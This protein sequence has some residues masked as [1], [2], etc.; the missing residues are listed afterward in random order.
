MLYY[1][2]FR[3][4]IRKTSSA[5][6]T[7]VSTSNSTANTKKSHS[8]VPNIN[9][10]NNYNFLANSMALQSLAMQYPT[11]SELNYSTAPS[12][13]IPY[14]PDL[15]MIAAAAVGLTPQ[16]SSLSLSQMDILSHI[17]MVNTKYPGN[18][19][20]AKSTSPPKK[21]NVPSPS[22]SS[23]RSTTPVSASASSTSSISEKKKSNDTAASK[24]NDMS[25]VFP[26][27]T[28]DVFKID[29]L[30]NSTKTKKEHHMLNHI[31]QYNKHYS[32]K[33]EKKNTYEKKDENVPSVSPV[34]HSSSSNHSVSNI[35]SKPAVPGGCAGASA[36]I[37]LGQNKIGI[38]DQVLDLSPNKIVKNEVECDNT[39]R[40][41]A[42]HSSSKN[43]TSTSI[44]ASSAV[45]AK[46]HNYW[47]STGKKEEITI[48]KEE[49]RQE[50]FPIIS[51]SA[52]NS[53]SV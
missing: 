11:Q 18:H 40:R 21:Q 41:S 45:T 14:H 33:T 36:N 37:D 13:G 50:A 12:T 25:N 42:H 32:H 29:S 2:D 20:Y 3:N 35:C 30:I 26:K 43:E 31:S 16:P 52:S 8:T 34:S 51:A 19:S 6:S 9:S 5:N 7:S 53:V 4:K 49:V 24:L 38:R 10:L 22:F 39:I 47:S 1:I 23:Q 28:T 44:A 15:N 17:A 27:H 48:K 46:D